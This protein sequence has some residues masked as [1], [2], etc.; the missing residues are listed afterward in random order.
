VWAVEH[1]R[2]VGEHLFA[3]LE[4]VGHA[5]IAFVKRRCLDRGERDFLY[6]AGVAIAAGQPR[7]CSSP[8]RASAPSGGT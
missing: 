3:F 7:R 4:N 2:M 1:G 5:G 6:P 8:P